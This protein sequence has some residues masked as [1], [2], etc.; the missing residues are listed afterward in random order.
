MRHAFLVKFYI[1]LSVSITASYIY[2]SNLIY[3][4]RSREVKISEFNIVVVIKTII[5]YI[6]TKAK[7]ILKLE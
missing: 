7:L 5:L 3:K 1:V 6:L 2:I 4:L